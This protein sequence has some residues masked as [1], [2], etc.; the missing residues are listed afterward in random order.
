VNAERPITAPSANPFP[1]PG[2]HELVDLPTLP[3]QLTQSPAGKRTQSIKRC[4]EKAYMKNWVRL[5]KF[6]CAHFA[7]P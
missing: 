2:G 5:F 6:D 4:P 1:V 7:T 3:T